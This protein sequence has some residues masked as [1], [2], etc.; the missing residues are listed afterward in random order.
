MK[1]SLP[2]SKSPGLDRRSFLRFSAIAG[3]G[4]LVAAY[5]EPFTKAIA[6]EHGPQTAQSYIASAFVKFMPNG[7]VTIYSKNPEIGQGIK[8]SLP[9]II[10]EELDVDWKDVTVEQADFD[11][12]RFG[13]QRSGG[14]GGT[15]SN[16]EPLRQVGAATRSMFVAAGAQTWN[17][18]TSECTTRAG[19]VVHIPSK[20]T[21][22][23]GELAA[24]VATMTPPELNAVTLKDPKD[25]KI[26]GHRIPGVDVPSIV[27]GKPI[28]SIDFTVP[29]MLWAVYE[30]CPVFAGKAKSANLDEIKAMPGVRNAFIIDGTNDLLGLVGG[31]AIVADSWWQANVA[32]KQLKVTWE[33]GPTARQNSDDFQRAADELSKKKPQFALRVDGDAEAAFQ[34]AAKIVEASYTYPFLSHA[35]MEPENC[36]AHYDNGKL[37]FWTPT[38]TPAQGRQQ[39]SKVMGIPE[40]NITIHMLRSGG[41]FG[42]RLTNDYML[43]SAWISR[44]VGAPV[45]LLWTR[46]D[47][48]QHDHYRPAGY[49]YLKGSLDAAG[50]LTA[51]KNHF[52]SFGENGDWQTPP[53]QIASNEFPGTFLPN[54][55]FQASLIPS[56]VPMFSLRAPGSNAYSWVFNS[57]IDELAVAAGKDAIQFRMEILSLPPFKN[58]NARPPNPG[59][60]PDIIPSRMRAVLQLAAEKSGWGKRTLPK[61]TAMGFAFQLALRGYFAE[62]AEVTVDANKKVKVHKMW[63]VGDIGRQIMNTSNAENLVQGAVVEGLSHAMNWQIT[64]DHGRAMQSNFHQYQPTRIS[65]APA[66]I[67][68]HFITSDNPPTGL[69]EPPLPPA[70]PAVCNAIFAVTGERI[71]SLPLAKHGYSWA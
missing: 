58:P 27:R 16:F 35:Q 1:T 43:E 26:V 49:H 29:N 32:R 23:Y 19:R 60:E 4:L 40:E 65:Q 39:V 68:V 53:A 38:Q 15:P 44:V 41:G 20:R 34:T 56:G 33:E 50:N 45:K 69:G 10:A 66:E 13:R 36:V 71:R 61:G 8:T 6:Q 51:W 12:A 63:V 2:E 57:F 55:D 9:M 54:F 5:I 31:V 67:E 37:V 18:E 30:K 70:A 62:V 24:K 22:S 25:F 42:R 64:I 59:A 11:E 21:L 7:G 28:Y 17:A 14:S 48:F 47:D 46:E 52:V 3:G